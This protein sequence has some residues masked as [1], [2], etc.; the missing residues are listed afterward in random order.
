LKT[1]FK[2]LG[3]LLGILLGIYALTFVF[4]ILGGLTSII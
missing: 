2:I 4:A 1:M 3:V